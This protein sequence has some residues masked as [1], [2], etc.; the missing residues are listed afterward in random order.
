MRRH[1]GR[2]A[3]L[4][5]ALIPSH[6]SAQTGFSQ[7]EAEALRL[8]QRGDFR[9]ASK[10]YLEFLANPAAD[11]RGAAV[12]EYHALMALRFARLTGDWREF[13]ES[14]SAA[15]TSAAAAQHPTLADRLAA[16][17]L[18]ANLAQGRHDD[19]TI[20]TRALGFLQDWWIIG[21]FDNERG[22][23]FRR[24]YGPQTELDLDASYD[25]KKRPVGWR[26]IPVP[27]APGGVVDL[28]AM[29][30]PNDQVLCYAATTLWA[31]EDC[32]V[33][34]RLGS[35]ESFAV[36]LNGDVVA[37]RDVRR[38]FAHDQDAI[39]LGLRAGPN[40]LMLKICDQEGAFAFAARLSANDGLPP[41]GI[42]CR[43]DRDAMQRAA[44]TMPAAQPT[45]LP[46]LGALTLF[47]RSVDETSDPTDAFRL[48]A[49][50]TVIQPD[51]PSARRDV[52]LAR[53]ATEG[54]PN[55]P[56]ARF[57]FAQTRIRSGASA[58]EKDDNARRHEYLRILDRVSGHGQALVAL[59]RM[60]L[61]GIG[62]QERAESR[63]R[64]ALAG[65]SEYVTARLLLARALRELGLEEL[66]DREVERA[67]APSAGL[68]FPE[69]RRELAGVLERRGDLA[70]AIAQLEMVLPLRFHHG[71]VGRLADLYLR[72]GRRDNAVDL[73]EQAIRVAPYTVQPYTRL[74]QLLEAEGD[75]DAAMEVHQRWLAIAP[76]DDEVI[77]H[78][79]RLHGLENRSELEREWL[80]TAVELNPNL[81]PEQ[82]LLDFLEDE[83]SPFYAAF[84]LEGDAILSADAGPPEDSEALNDPYYHLLDQRVI[85]AYRNGTRSEYRHRITHVLNEE[86]ARRMATRRVEHYRGEQRARLLD[87]RVVK[88]DGQE[89]RPRIYGWAVRLPP[90][91]PGDVVETRSRVDDVRPSFF[92]DYFG[93]EHRF[94]G[95][96][97]APCRRSVLVVS[98]DPGREYHT[99]LVNGAPSPSSETGPDGETIHRFEMTDLPRRKVEVRKPKGFESEPLV[100][101]STYRN[102]DHFSSW[103]WNL[104][105]KQTEPSEAI[106]AKVEE[107]TSGLATEQ[108][109]I[110]AIYDFV[111]TEIRYTAWEFGV[112]GYKPYTTPV[113][114]ERRHGDCKDKSLLLNSMLAEIGVEAYPTLIR[115]DPRRSRDDLSLPLI[116]HFNHC[117][118]YLPP[119]DERPEM[120]LDGT[121]TYHPTD[122]LP[123]GDQGA[124][125][126]VVRGP[127]GEVREITWDDP[128]A[129]RRA[130]TATITLDEQG[131]AEV[132]MVER[133]TGN[134]AVPVRATFGNEP[135]KR[136]EKLERNLAPH[137]GSI[138][139]RE[140]ACSDLLDMAV[141]AE[142]RV[143]FTAQ[144]FA[145]RRGR[146]LVVRS[147]LEPTPLTQL[148][149]NP[150]RTHPLLLGAPN[151]QTYSLVYRLPP[152]YAPVELPPPTE[153]EEA[154]G[155]FRLDCSFDG[156]ELRIQRMLSTS[157]N[158]IEPSDYPR[159]REFCAAVDRADRR[160]I[161]LGKEGGN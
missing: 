104:I 159:F 82:R 7:S 37:A 138:E 146:E 93:I 28:N 130:V 90:L 161:V 39:P 43:A 145:Q 141:P 13:R 60:D 125:V 57:L 33:V 36:I 5:C 96:D 23:G 113:I 147:T 18:Q 31:D 16:Y 98:L 73:L 121:A 154:F 22:V 120:Y 115:L 140:V 29:V 40:L 84:E 122:T 47:A 105:R 94:A 110:A 116:R 88:K 117:I 114:F 78:V 20:S 92:G 38:S 79:A 62:A 135:A 35:D 72:A 133:P 160:V 143:D 134:Q 144:Q 34:L 61:D 107:L 77:V 149:R 56:A 27:D 99:Q 44:S 153:L 10:I 127:T 111:T 142:L 123:A 150:D 70:G 46:Y 137:F 50:L 119:T 11:E 151:S 80:R 1:A 3:L 58:A 17:E 14:L 53:R 26:R 59:A 102:W 108:E 12:A 52:D 42:T 136:R 9:A 87:V 71:L 8:E 97:G 100:R 45:E 30:R 51:D 101:I 85:R 49:L 25:G 126:L 83:E 74:A 124:R 19:I 69:A 76:E 106:R 128:A 24:E 157:T 81:K 41:N 6:A 156:S 152:G 148:A 65:N 103:W 48:A 155:S 55:E 89:I 54:M 21:P 109:K 66:A 91:E 118:S 131:D 63:L 139:V 64:S 67:N 158:R 95:G 32:E 15:R 2:M 129:N 68:P 75:I 4:C 132:S 112:H 86:G